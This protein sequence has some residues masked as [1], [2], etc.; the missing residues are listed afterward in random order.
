MEK[1]V[2]T[3]YDPNIFAVFRKQITGA[4][5]LNVVDNVSVEDLRKGM[6]LAEA[7]RTAGGLK[8]LSAETILTENHLRRIE[9]YA[10]LFDLHRPLRVYRSQTHGAQQENG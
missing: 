9:N 1:D 3:R 2:G 4:D 8:L 10:S 6:I 5:P 7:V